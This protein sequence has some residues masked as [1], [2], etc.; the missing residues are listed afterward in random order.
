MS[1]AL[2]T[3]AYTILPMV[4]TEWIDVDSANGQP[5][6]LSVRVQTQKLQNLY[7]KNDYS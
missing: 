6:T 1:N 3:I 5:F 4:N 2:A 7:N